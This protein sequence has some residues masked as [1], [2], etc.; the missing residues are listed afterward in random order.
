M[1]NILVLI[2][3][4]LTVMICDGQDVSRKNNLSLS[5]GPGYTA[6]QDLIFSPFIHMDLSFVNLG[7]DYSHESRLFQKVHLGF[8]GFNPVMVT[9]QYQFTIYGEIEEAYP[10]N[11]TI[12]NIDYLIGKKIR[13]RGKSNLTAGA[14]FTTDIHAMNYVFG[15][16]SSF[17]Y[18]AAFGL[19]LFGQEEVTIKEKSSFSATLKLPLLAWMARSPYL[20]NDDEYIE[21][22]SSHSGLRIFTAFVADGELVTWNRMQTFDLEVKYAYRLLDRWEV[23]TA[24]VLEFIHS[25]RSRNLLSYRNSLNFSANFRF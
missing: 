18:Y 6:R 8:A 21:N 16:I 14:L 22:T 17:G 4:W 5:W 15:R 20:V 3:T 24:Y 10:H 1:R 13:E 23:G 11:F 19:G 25:S 2:V 7:L 9:D 12:V